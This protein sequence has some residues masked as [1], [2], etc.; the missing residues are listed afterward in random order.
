[1]ANELIKKNPYNARHLFYKEIH[2]LIEEMQE[3]GP[4][5]LKGTTLVEF[6]RQIG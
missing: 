3:T 4:E 5:D 2:L 1:M 6:L